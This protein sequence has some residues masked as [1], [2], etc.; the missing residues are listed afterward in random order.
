MPCDLLDDVTLADAGAGPYAVERPAYS[1]R[2][3]M[4]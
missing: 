4:L 2:W 1:Y 3:L